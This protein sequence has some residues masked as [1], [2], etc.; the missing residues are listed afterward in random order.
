MAKKRL[1]LI[2]LISILFCPILSANNRSEKFTTHV[3][4]TCYNAEKRQ[5]NDDFVHTSDN[6]LIDFKKLKQGKLKWVAISRNLLYVIPLGSLIHIEGL[7]YYEVHDVMN[8]RFKHRI[9][10]LQ[11]HNEKPFKLDNVKV[12]LIRKGYKK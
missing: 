6:S 3:V 10:I 1:F 5:C 9:D 12:K 2:L 7:G 8:K 11:H 4:V